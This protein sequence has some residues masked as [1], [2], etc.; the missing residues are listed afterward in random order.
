MIGEPR[1]PLGGGGLE[2]WTTCGRQGR[3]LQ[4][5]REALVKAYSFDAYSAG[6]ERQMVVRGRERGDSRGFLSALG[7]FQQELIKKGRVE[8]G[9]Y[10]HVGKT[11]LVMGCG[12]S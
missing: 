11:N 4:E 7:Q 8:T 12:M 10:K 5:A 1:K 3:I 2:G 9:E 6:E